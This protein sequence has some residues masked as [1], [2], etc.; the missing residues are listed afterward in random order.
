MRYTLFIQKFPYKKCEALLFI[1]HTRSSALEFTQEFLKIDEKHE[2]IQ[3]VKNN[4]YYYD[5]EIY[6]EELGIEGCEV[7]LFEIPIDTGD[8]DKLRLSESK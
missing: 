6:L 5:E 2:I 8:G 1:F 4:G 7:N 3:N